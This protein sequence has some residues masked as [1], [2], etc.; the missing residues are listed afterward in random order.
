M[1][2]TVTLNPSVDINYKLPTLEINDANRVSDVSKTAGGK[3]LNV[4]RVLRQ[5]DET[6]AATGYIGGVLSDFIRQEIK[7]LDIADFFV[8]TKGETRNCIAII[9]DDGKQTEVLEKG[10]DIDADEATKFIEKYKEMIADV[11]IIT[12]SGSLPKGLDT[13]FY[14]K[15]ID[16]ANAQDKKVLLDSSGETL[17]QSIQKSKP[18]LIKPNET[19]LGQILGRAVETEEEVIAALKTDLFAHLPY[20]FV[21]LGADGALVKYEEKIYQAKIPVV[22]AVNPVGSGDATIAGIAH[23]IQKNWSVE[24]TIKSGLT[25]GTLN[26]LEEKTGHIDP[27]NWAHI[28]EKIEVKEI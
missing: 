14:A 11:D 7:Q 21:T 19:E 20:V 13:D 1:I 9:H 25:C 2:L 18:Y 28:F 24:N 3:G 10:P 26:A 5:L 8:E 22:D 27:N 17:L 15:L 16:L 4:S 12:I 6:V 23:G